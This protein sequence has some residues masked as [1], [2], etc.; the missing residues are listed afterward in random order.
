MKGKMIISAK[1][2]PTKKKEEKMTGF[3]WRNSVM[4]SPN[5]IGCY[6]GPAEKPAHVDF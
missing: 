6:P 1:E 3:P 2:E 4:G 5:E